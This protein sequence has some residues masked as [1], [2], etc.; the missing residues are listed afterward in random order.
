MSCG[1]QAALRKDLLGFLLVFLSFFDRV[2]GFVS[3][4]LTRRPVR[5]CVT[6][7]N[8]PKAVKIFASHTII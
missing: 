7:E 3:Q 6:A 5:V 8:L 2:W 4:I 1:L